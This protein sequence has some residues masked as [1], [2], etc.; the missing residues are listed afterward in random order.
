[1]VLPWFYGEEKGF[2][3]YREYWP[4]AL[5]INMAYEQIYQKIQEGLKVIEGPYASTKM[6]FSAWGQFYTDFLSSHG[7]PRELVTICGNPSY[8][9]YL[10]P[11]RK[12]FVDR[13]ALANRHGL[14]SGK[15]W[16]FFPENYRAAFM[17]REQLDRFERTMNQP[18]ISDH[19]REFAETSLR[20]VC[21]WLEDVPEGTQ[22]ILRPRPA[23]GMEPFVAK[24]G[25][26]LEGFKDRVFITTDATVR[27]WILASDLTISSYSTSLIEASLA[28]KDIAILE[29]VSFPDYARYD[30]CDLVGSART[31]EGARGLWSGESA[32]GDGSA[33]KAWAMDLAMAGGDPLANTAAWIASVHSEN[34]QGIAERAD[35]KWG[36]KAGLRAAGD[37]LKWRLRGQRER[38]PMK[39]W[40]SDEDAEARTAR[41]REILK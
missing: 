40:F 38:I 14:D 15:R 29:P 22:V 10:E 34:P 12:Y 39:D 13:A 1:V 4:Q 28:D 24:V 11:Y 16:V 31:R 27:E 21:R 8:G 18:G 2:N 41:W 25:P 33:L 35:G 3:R 26:W 6:R 30:W 37:S 9:L 36:M 19:F 32:L 23:V 17:S 5:I 20:E 7:I